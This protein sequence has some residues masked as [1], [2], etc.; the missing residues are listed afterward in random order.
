MEDTFDALHRIGTAMTA[1]WDIIGDSPHATALTAL[2][3][4]IF[5]ELDTQ[6][7]FFNGVGVVVAQD[8]LADRARYLEWWRSDPSGGPFRPLVL[9]L[10]PRSEFFYDYPTMEWFSIPRDRGTPAVH[11][12]YLDYTGVDLYICT[13]AV[14]VRSRRGTFLGIAGADVPVRA[15]DAALMPVFRAEGRPLALINGEGRVI[16]ANH[17]DHVTGSRLRA[18]LGAET[19][20]VP[21]TSWSL[22]SLGAQV[23]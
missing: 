19:H 14:P 17:V 20:S 9:D 2:R 21:G 18:G 12:P 1:L 5:A 22:V 4:S 7:T 15:I 6:G 13:F 8:V 3:T 10:D 16:V 23:S 11:G